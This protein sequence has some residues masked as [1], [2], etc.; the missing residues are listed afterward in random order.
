MDHI[1]DSTRNRHYLNGASTVLHCH[2]YTTLI[3]QLAEDAV[4][5]DGHR[6]LMEAAEECF[7]EVLGKYYQTYEIDS[8]E[9]KV[10]AAENYWKL[11]G[12]GIIRFTSIGRY[13]VTAEMDYSHV[14]EG[15]LKKW[16]GHDKPVNFITAGFVAAVAAL[17]TNMERRS[18]A[19]EQTKGLVCGDDV[20]AFRAVYR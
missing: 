13:D 15:W 5:F 10:Q 20:S 16:G 17:A 18:F 2:H 4:H 8:V 6:F 19:V 1:Y 11:V 14:D 7:Y 9:E 12:M 3:T